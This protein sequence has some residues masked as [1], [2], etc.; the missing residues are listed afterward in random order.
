MALLQCE[1]CKFSTTQKRYLAEHNR[2]ISWTFPIIYINVFND[3]LIFYET[4]KLDK[5]VPIIKNQNVSKYIKCG[6]GQNKFCPYLENFS[7]D[8]QKKTGTLEPRPGSRVNVGL[9]FGE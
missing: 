2:W 8:L 1:M 5:I 6:E 9:L 3:Q 4:F 7:T